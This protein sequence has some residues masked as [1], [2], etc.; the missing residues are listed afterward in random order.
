MPRTSGMI[1]NILVNIEIDGEQIAIAFA[2]T[3]Y[4]KMLD[5]ATATRRT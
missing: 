4:A 2:Q 1:R 3:E 5:Y